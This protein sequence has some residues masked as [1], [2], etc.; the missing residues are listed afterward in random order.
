[1][2]ITNKPMLIRVGNS[3]LNILLTAY[4]KSVH[5]FISKM[6]LHVKVKVLY[7]R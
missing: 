1:M 7:S 2:A 6:A 3:E 4:G 5:T